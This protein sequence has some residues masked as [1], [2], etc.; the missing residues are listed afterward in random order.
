[1]SNLDKSKALFIFIIIIS[2]ELAQYKEIYKLFLLLLSYKK[3]YFNDEQK[4]WKTTEENK[5]F[6]MTSGSKSALGTVANG[7]PNNNL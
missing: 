6:R 4:K 2:I 5:I 3:W 1:M 7:L